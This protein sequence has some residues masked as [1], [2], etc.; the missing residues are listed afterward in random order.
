MKK[1]IYPRLS[2]RDYGWFRVGGN[3]LANC[4]LVAA[5]A[6]LRAQAVGA[7]MLRPTWERLGLGTWLRRERDKRLYV[8]LFKGWGGRNCAKVLFVRLFRSKQIETVAWKQTYYESLWGH[9]DEIRRFFS[10][11]IDPDAIRSV[12]LSMRRSVAVHVRL[13]DFPAHYRTPISWYRQM[14]ECLQAY[15]QGENLDIQLFSDGTDE[16][17]APLL[18]LKGARRVYYGNAL[19][20]MIAISRCGFLIGSDSTF[21]AWGAFLGDLPCVFAHLNDY[22]IFSTDNRCRVLAENDKIPESL[23]GCFKG[24]FCR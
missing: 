6:Y 1:Y 3:G 2:N 8:G 7:E 5:R 18:S 12:P 15:C 14:I 11:I 23:V 24:G 17:L 4:M 9:E 13:S 21:S 19:A 22:R 10:G 20:D 16:E